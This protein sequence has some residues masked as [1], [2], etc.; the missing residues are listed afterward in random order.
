MTGL[1]T[2]LEH[3][4]APDIGPA[5]EPSELS[6]RLRGRGSGVWGFVRAMP[7]SVLLSSLWLI[8][9][10]AAAL[11][12]PYLP[13]IEDPNVGI[14]SGNRPNEAPSLDHWLGTDNNSR[15]LFART[16]YGARVSLTVSATAVAFGLVVGG[17]LGAAV[18]YYRGKL[19]ALTMAATDVILAFPGLVLLLALVAFLGSQDLL[20]IA[21]AVGLLSIPPYTRVSRANA[22]GVANREYVLAARAI[23]TKRF[24]IL[25]RE[26]IPNVLPSLVAFALVGAAVVVVLEGSLAFL[27][28]SVEAPTATWGAMINEGRQNIRSVIHPVLFPA[29]A[30]FFTV[31][32]LNNIGDWLRRR[33]AVRAAAL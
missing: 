11:L 24:A 10:F 19:E 17:L 30:M 31:F 13:F 8:F 33:N 5:S 21:I 12:A 6:T 7:P 23:G 1:D 14:T 27:G 2:S 22:L 32:S 18:G 15:D 9:I 25:R 29:L 16:I 3:A 4:P 26:I 28:L 20:T